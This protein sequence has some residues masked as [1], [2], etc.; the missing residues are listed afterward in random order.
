MEAKKRNI[1][2]LYGGIAGLFMILFTLVLYLGGVGLF[3]SGI[4]RLGY[5]IL[6]GLA[7]TA[8]LMQRKA[9]GGWL[10]FQAALKTA[11][12]V[13]VLALAAQTL[14]TWILLTFVDTH[15]KAVLSKAVLDDMEAAVRKMPLSRDIIERTITDERGK[16]QFSFGRVSLGFAF[17]CIIHFIIALLIAAI[18]KKK[19]YEPAGAG[20]GA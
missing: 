18:V 8:T 5:V 13:M 20:A 7:V 15:F 10:D 6:I 4:A 3:L 14:F 11:F 9:N 16:D 17:S 12:V 2:L 19:K 1:G